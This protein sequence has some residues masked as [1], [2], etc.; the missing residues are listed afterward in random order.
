MRLPRLLEMSF[1]Y[2]NSIQKGG[3]FLYMGHGRNTHK[4]PSYH[5]DRKREKRKQKNPKITDTKQKNPVYLSMICP[6]YD[7]LLL[8]NYLHLD[9][10]RL[11]IWFPVLHAKSSQRKG[12]KHLTLFIAYRFYRDR[13]FNL[14]NYSI[15]WRLSLDNSWH[16]S[17]IT[18][19]TVLQNLIL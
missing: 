4:T 11:I 3:N 8:S 1:S 5:Q 18:L 14:N 10:F 16:F 13:W 12:I 19:I 15:F 17:K 9:C 2:F 6:L 7:W